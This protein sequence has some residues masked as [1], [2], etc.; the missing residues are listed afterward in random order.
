MLIGHMFSIIKISM[1]G[2]LILIISA[3]T[4]GKN[5]SGETG[6]L[7]ISQYYGR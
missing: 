1:T 5:F 6:L 7:G 4:A 3:F 2:I